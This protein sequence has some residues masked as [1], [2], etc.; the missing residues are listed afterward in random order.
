[1]EEEFLVEYNNLKKGILLGK[2]GFSDVHLCYWFR[3]NRWSEIAVKKFH[4]DWEE[5]TSEKRAKTVK[6]FQR[7]V[8]ALR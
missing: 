4:V 3:N 2:G 6:Y 5:M 1:M 7:E 8:E